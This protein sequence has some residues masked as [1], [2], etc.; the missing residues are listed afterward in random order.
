MPTKPGRILVQA[1]VLGAIGAGIGLAHSAISPVMIERP[2]PPKV[3]DLIGKGAPGDSTPGSHAP[4]PG[5]A[6]S[7]PAAPTDKPALPTSPP[8][9][10]TPK[11]P[12]PGAPEKAA[13]Q[14]GLSDDLKAK[15]HITIDQAF[16][17]FSKNPTACFVDTRHKAD[18][19]EGHIPGAFRMPLAAFERKPVLLDL[20]D[21]ESPV[22]VY[23]IGGNCDESEAVAKQFNLAGY[24]MVYVMHDGFPGW[25][26]AGK[27]VETGP[28]QEEA[29]D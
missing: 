9:S 20:I 18:Y 10:D 23:C 6:A 25:K 11:P 7:N 15:G 29:A 21:R 2:A 5:P 14:P 22:V 4:Q 12:A 3:D 16:A 28:G 26:G 8:S 13:P 27:A 1:I 19:H 24:K 17:L